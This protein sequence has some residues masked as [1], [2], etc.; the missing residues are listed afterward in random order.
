MIFAI[1]V[2]GALVAAYG[3]YDGFLTLLTLKFVMSSGRSL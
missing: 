2:V 3:L 1:V